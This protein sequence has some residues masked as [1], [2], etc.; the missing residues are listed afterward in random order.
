MAHYLVA[1]VGSDSDPAHS[2]DVK[3]W[4]Y[5]YKWRLDEEDEVCV[6]VGNDDCEC[7]VPGDTLWFTIDG[8]LVGKT[9]LLR[10]MYDPFNGRKELWFNTMDCVPV[11]VK[12]QV[13]EDL[14][15]GIIDDTQAN[16]FETCG[17][18]GGYPVEL[19]S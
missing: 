6:P 4:F 5:F 16:V 19:S 18:K 1:L 11:V 14:H 13:F 2:G 17:Y 8:E 15:T 9:L 10:V 7:A 12:E 3:S